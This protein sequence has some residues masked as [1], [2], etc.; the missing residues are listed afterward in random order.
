M[1][2]PDWRLPP[3]VTRSLWEF[4][5]DRE[6]ARDE[7][8]HLAGAA[9]LEFDHRVVAGWFATPG[10][11]VDLG[12]GTGRSLVDFARRGF[13]CLGIDLSHEALLV[14]DE[15]IA[16][17]RQTAGLVQGNLCALECLTD[18]EFDYALLLFGTLGMVSGRDYRRRIL[19]HARRILKPGGFL[20]LHVHNVWRHLNSPQGRGWLVRDLAK[21]LLGH[22]T[23]GD[24]EHAYRGV[25]R[26]YHHAFTRREIIALLHLCGFAIRE[27]IPL[28][29][30]DH[31][32]ESSAESKS[33]GARDL[34]CWGWLRNWRAT[35][36][37]ILAQARR[38]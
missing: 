25:P 37:L 35:G 3:G 31:S 5:H 27:M 29:P 18:R 24:S 38:P 4:A 14:A 16:A 20:A 26:M 2:I 34:A 13:D 19:E 12:C 15:R 6:I 28:A 1:S 22:P 10:R 17:A 7:A 21:R 33:D 9:L 11:L 36:W 30:L 32:A 23:A 8:R